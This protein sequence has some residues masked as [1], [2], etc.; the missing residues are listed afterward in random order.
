M[1][2]KA[3][4]S[5]AGLISMYAGEVKELTDEESVSLLSCGYIKPIEEIEKKPVE[6]LEEIIEEEINEV[7]GEV[8]E[9]VEVT[10]EKKN[11][12]SRKK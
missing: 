2:Y 1:K 10:E 7:P 11:K 8:A 6:V 12:S 5:F 3:V 9:Q 4:I